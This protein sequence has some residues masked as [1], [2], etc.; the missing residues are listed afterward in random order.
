MIK[1]KSTNL[2]DIV[3]TF[4]LPAYSYLLLLLLLYLLLV[5]TECPEKEERAFT[6][7]SRHFFYT[8]IN[9]SAWMSLVVDQ[10]F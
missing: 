4:A 1:M 3:H 6:P 10:Q 9:F 2:Q 8:E 7:T 5:M